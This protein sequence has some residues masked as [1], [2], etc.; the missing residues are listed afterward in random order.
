M[1]RMKLAVVASLLLS[2]GVAQAAKKNDVFVAGKPLAEQLQRIEVE[3]GDGKTYSELKL[4]DRSRVREALGRMRITLE[5]FPDESRIPDVA[6]TDLFND[7]QVVNT[8][9]TQARED[10]RL[11]CRR[12]KAT[13]SNFAVTQCLTLAERER[14]K[15]DA[16]QRMNR[17]QRVGNSDNF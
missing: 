4:E 1:K 3:M 2:A 11:I 5:R 6:K 9:L 12:E 13:G 7:Q 15:N 10:S 16:Q 14:N 17:A 8:V